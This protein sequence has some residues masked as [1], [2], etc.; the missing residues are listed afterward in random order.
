MGS[1]SSKP[2]KKAQHLPKVAKYEEP[3]QLEGASGGGFGRD[4]HSADHHG[5]DKPT[6]F[7]AWVLK[8]LGREPK[9]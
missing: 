2:R 4:G 7:G 8:V 1:D 9:P 5:H 3:N 6:G